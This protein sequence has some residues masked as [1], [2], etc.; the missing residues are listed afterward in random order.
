MDKSIT[1]LLLV[2]IL[3][4]GMSCD[5]SRN[6]EKHQNE[7]DSALSIDSFVLDAV[8]IDHGIS[9]D[10]AFA[11]MQLQWEDSDTGCLNVVD[12][13]VE[14]A[15]VDSTIDSQVV[16][17]DFSPLP[18]CEGI[19]VPPPGV[20]SDGGVEICNYY[21]DDGD[22]LVDEG[23]QY[24]I[25]SGPLDFFQ[26]AAEF[27]PI[28]PGFSLLSNESRL[29]E[30]VDEFGI[31]WIHNKNRENVAFKPW[32]VT[33]GTDGCPK[34]RSFEL[35]PDGVFGQF[36]LSVSHVDG[37]YYT[38]FRPEDTSSACV[39]HYRHEMGYRA[40]IYEVTPGTTEANGLLVSNGDKTGFFFSSFGEGTGVISTSAFVEIDSNEEFPTFSIEAVETYSL[41][42]SGIFFG[43]D[44]IDF[45]KDGAEYILFFNGDGPTVGAY[46]LKWDERGGV[47]QPVTKIGPSGFGGVASL[48]NGRYMYLVKSFGTAPIFR[49]YGPGGEAYTITNE[50]LMPGLFKNREY[51]V[52]DE[53]EQGQYFSNLLP[54]TEG[55][56]Q[57]RP[58]VRIEG[59]RIAD[60]V[61]RTGQS[62]VLLLTAKRYDSPLH[63]AYLGCA[64]M[65]RDE[66]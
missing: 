44:M 53:V 12:G 27:E 39:A 17:A 55:G 10:A 34:H 14:D 20:P 13:S 16:D 43:P 35:Y 18:G 47:T 4:L 28:S 48:G 49:H 36:P 61:S 8:V 1:L 9:T 45:V 60:I 37:S 52:F 57:Y 59:L 50:E 21:D 3:L 33:V 7:A 32:F 6:S 42:D 19:E 2:H 56:F 22:G 5:E 29:V 64:Q 15:S 40:F 31:A 26:Y 51:Y 46:V 41:F 25:L 66:K 24:E 65:Y 11:D 63:I 30:G 23:M 58:T 54:V 62:D 38:I